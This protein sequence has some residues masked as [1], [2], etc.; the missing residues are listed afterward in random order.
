MYLGNIIPLSKEKTLLAMT[1]DRKKAV[2]IVI[3]F[4]LLAVSLVFGAGYFFEKSEN[5]K[6]QSE[7]GKQQ[8]NVK[9]INFSNLFIEKVLKAKTE[10]SFED[11][12]KLENDVRAL[13]DSVILGLWEKFTESSTQDQAQESVKN[14]LD[15]L[16]KKISH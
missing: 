1:I 11:R 6:M 7:L 2:I 13:N 4:I 14:L 10:V 15:A 8:L 16:V 3:I 9:V 5:K 12:L